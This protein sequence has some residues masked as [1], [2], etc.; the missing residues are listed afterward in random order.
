MVKYTTP[1]PKRQAIYPWMSPSTPR[2]RCVHAICSTRLSTLPRLDANQYT[3][4]PGTRGCD[5]MSR[6]RHSAAPPHRF[7]VTHV[8][9]RSAVSRHSASSVAHYEPQAAAQ[10]T[11]NGTRI[12]TDWTDSRGFL[13]MYLCISVESVQ[14]VSYSCLAEQLPTQNVTSSHHHQDAG[15][16]SLRVRQSGDG[17]G[18]SETE[19][20]RIKEH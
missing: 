9:Q 16:H 3:P 19:R 5:R 13:R 4:L 18:V 12:P 17:A 2:H 10:R 11:G 1:G 20:Q 14:S 7:V 15:R 8:A 6:R